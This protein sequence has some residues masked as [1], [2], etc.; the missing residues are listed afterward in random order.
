MT[1]PRCSPGYL[2]AL[3]IFALLPYDAALAQTSTSYRRN[4]AGG[5]YSD[6]GNWF[7]GIPLSNAYFDTSGTYTVNVDGNASLTNAIF[8]AGNLNATLDV[9]ATSFAV[10]QMNVGGGVAGSN[11]QVTVGG[12]LLMATA[13]QIAPSLGQGSLVV[14]GPLR[15]S[16]VVVG[17]QASF[18]GF[19][20]QTPGGQGTLTLNAG[21]QLT[22]GGL[23]ADNAGAGSSVVFNGGTLTILGQGRFNQNAA[24]QSFTRVGNGL[25][26]AVLNLRNGSVPGVY[27]FGS[28]TLHISTNSMVNFDS[29]G[30]SLSVGNLQRDTGIGSHGAFNWTA[31]QINLTNAPLELRSTGQFS[32]S[33][34][35]TSARSLVADVGTNISN[36]ASL[37]LSGGSLT[38]GPIVNSGGNFAF[39]SGNLSLLGDF[40]IGPTGQLNQ[41]PNLTVG[42]DSSINVFDGLFTIQPTQTISIDGGYVTANTL[43]NKGS[44]TVVN[45]SLSTDSLLASDGAGSILNFNGGF[46]NT[47]QSVI[48]G[49]SE[50]IVGNGV[51]NAQFNMVGG[52]T[53]RFVDGLQI[54]AS[55]RL[56]GEGTIIGNLV[57]S[58]LIAPGNSPGVVDLIG[59]FTNQGL[60]EFE[61][62]SPELFDEF[63]LS[64]NFN[65]G[66]V[67]AVRLLGFQP[68]LGDTFDLIDFNT[69]TDTGYAFDFTQAE[70]GS[71]LVWDTSGFSTTGGIGVVAVPEPSGLAL[72]GLAGLAGVLFKRRRV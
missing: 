4:P 13:V 20:S 55:G 47:A 39:S 31:G 42:T 61:I 69:F 58:G 1:K 35:L 71:G 70:L 56:T 67:I 24:P 45:G 44:I 11:N 26:S 40:T 27:D 10:S 2:Y 12:N 22:A 46:I 28:Q 23:L 9:S 36:G 53:H 29:P 14:N 5:R 18:P 15:S 49:P 51:T 60:I 66:G 37:A 52:G 21:A 34:N 63:R 17:G 6:G 50:F 65:A 38:S 3:A 72:L 30:G 25:Q 64:G 8:F 59:S 57:N 62:E 48:D 54:S 32:S 43:W 68:E 33:L 7:G 16:Y 41:T 19:F